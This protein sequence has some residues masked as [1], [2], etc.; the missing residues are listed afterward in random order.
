MTISFTFHTIEFVRSENEIITIE[1]ISPAK[2]KTDSTYK[3]II[4][5]AEG[6]EEMTIH[7]PHGSQA[8]RVI[9][10]KPSNDRI[11]QCIS[12]LSFSKKKYYYKDSP[13]QTLC[14]S[15]YYKKPKTSSIHT[16]EKLD[17]APELILLELKNTPI[18]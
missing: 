12:C 9:R 5:N 14:K 11:P 7:H 17:I 8:R 4:T 18:P 1:E 15:C 3:K 13:N 2:K 10:R 16:V 6:K